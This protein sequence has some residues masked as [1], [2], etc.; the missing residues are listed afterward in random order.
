MQPS[1]IK[2][3]LTYLA[4]VIA[5]CWLIAG[6]AEAQPIDL[7]IVKHKFATPLQQQQISEQGFAKLLQA[8]KR[9]PLG[10]LTVVDDTLKLNDISQYTSRLG[11]WQTLAYEK[12]W[13]RHSRQCHLSLPPVFDSNGVD[14]GGGV[15][16]GQC[17]PRAA[18][19]SIARMLNKRNQARLYSSITDV[20]HE[21]GHLDGAGHDQDTPNIMD[22]A[23]SSKYG[24]VSLGFNGKA[25]KQIRWCRK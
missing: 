3:L 5:L 13:C 24:E 6:V 12:G 1:L 20:A 10:K 18:S 22:E 14:Y 21:V 11:D 16:D 15:A 17:K 4:I 9:H 19:Y 2:I 23:A 8:G 25:I 7:V